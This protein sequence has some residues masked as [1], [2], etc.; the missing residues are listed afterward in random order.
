MGSA[1]NRWWPVF[2][3]DWREY[4]RNWGWLLASGIFSIIL[5]L[6]ALVD[7]LWATIASILVFG[8]LLLIAGI[9][10]AVQT[11]RHRRSGH[12]FFHALNAALSF[13]V[14]LM[15]LRHPLAGALVMTLLLGA[16]FTVIGIF[17]MVTAL[18]LRFPHWGWN[19]MSG[20]ITLILGILVWQQWPGSGLWII[21]LFTGIHLIVSGWAEVML[22]SA[23]RSFP[24]EPA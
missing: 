3:E 24:P 1:S 20:I 6:I 2:G 4:R 10:E 14:G 5:G 15:M 17:H 12:V 19:V 23:V 7:S 9:V 22:A 18:S 16:Y 8:W 11:F 21:G 13:V